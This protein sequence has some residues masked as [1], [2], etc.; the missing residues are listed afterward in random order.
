MLGVFH[1]TE[2]IN[3][4]QTE[5]YQGR[6]TSSGVIIS[7]LPI[8]G[9]KKDQNS[10]NVLMKAAVMLSGHRSNLNKIIDREISTS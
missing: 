6:V 8:K 3:S 1:V 7:D 9:E 5:Q 2:N 4:F 10:N